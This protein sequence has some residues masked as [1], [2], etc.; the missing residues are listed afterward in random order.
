MLQTQH[1]RA[2]IFLQG[3]GDAASEVTG[4]H[5]SKIVP[6]PTPLL[7]KESCW[8]NWVGGKARAQLHT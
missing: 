7:R 3:G 1:G 2:G 8:E 6:K 5:L 4:S